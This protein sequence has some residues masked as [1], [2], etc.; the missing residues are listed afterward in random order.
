MEHYGIFWNVQRLFDPNG[1]PVARELDAAGANWTNSHYRRKIHNIVECLRAIT[2]DQPP[3]V[4]ALAEVESTR[5]LQDI[6]K[7]AGWDDL[8][9]VDELVPDNTIDGLD[10]ALLFNKTLFDSKSLKAQSL[11]L[12]NRFATRDLLAVRLALRSNSKEVMFAVAHWPSRVVSEGVTLR[13]AYSIYLQRHVEAVL[14]F[15]KS[16]VVDAEGKT[17]L[18]PAEEL[19][20]RWSIPCFLM[21][22]FNDEPYDPSVRLAL[23]TTRSSQLVARRGKLKGKALTHVSN[24]LDTGVV[25]Y[26]PC[27]NL[28]F[29]DDD[30]KIGG[31]Y[32]RSEWRTYDHLIVSHGAVSDEGALRLVAGSPRPFRVRYNLGTKRKPVEMSTRGGFPKKFSPS[33]LDGVSD[34]FPLVFKLAV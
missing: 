34:H 22:D 33:A 17:T 6:R 2:D 9:I 19:L 23:Q 27:W 28:A 26:N 7:T 31:T 15:S 3:A 25:L 11:S 14:K 13:F 30:T 16:D 4:L 18:P 10:V 12:D 29:D 20:E 21:G 1:L 5:V 8:V 24:Y 32:Y